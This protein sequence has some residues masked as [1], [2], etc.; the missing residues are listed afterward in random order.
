[1]RKIRCI[2][3]Y[4]NFVC[5]NSPLI[6]I[7][8]I[9]FYFCFQL[10]LWTD[11]PNI[12]SLKFHFIFTN[13][14]VCILLLLLLLLESDLSQLN[15]PIVGIEYGIFLESKGCYQRANPLSS[16]CS[17]TGRLQLYSNLFRT[18]LFSFKFIRTI[19]I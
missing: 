13:K 3:S 4:S 11:K 12:F 6:F 10:E 19:L 17:L 1:M 8:K 14:N 16:V 18:N 5:T 15:P 7:T 2:Q 9:L